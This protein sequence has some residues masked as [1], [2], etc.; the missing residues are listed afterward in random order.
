MAA[1][2]AVITGTASKRL[3]IAGKAVKKKYL[4]PF[5]CYANLSIA[6]ALRQHL[7]KKK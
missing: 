3:F 6:S 5:S 2:M 4:T 1:T 7:W